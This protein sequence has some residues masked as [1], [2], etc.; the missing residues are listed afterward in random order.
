MTGMA[1]EEVE[2]EVT[3]LRSVW[4]LTEPYRFL[5]ERHD[6]GAPHIEGD[7]EPFQYV[8]TERGQDLE[9]REIAAAELIFET[10]SGTA[11]GIAFRE[12]LRTRGAG[13]YSRD[14]W[15]QGHIRLIGMVSEDWA[16]RV[17]RDYDE[18]LRRHPL[19]HEERRHARRLDLSAFGLAA[20]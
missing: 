11:Q 1:L 19:S 20:G 8:V 17:T 3:R 14:T 9:R 5:R 15:M 18:L 16:V 13:G 7:I 4:G 6:M 10:V 12:E 2:A